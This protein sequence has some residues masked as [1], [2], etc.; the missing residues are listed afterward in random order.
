MGMESVAFRQRRVLFPSVE[1][2]T[3]PAGFYLGGAPEMGMTNSSLRRITTR[4]SQKYHK[5]GMLGRVSSSLFIA[6]IT[7]AFASAASG[8]PLAPRPL[9]PEPLEKYDNPPAPSRMVQFSPGRVSQFGSFTSY[10]VNVDGNGNNIVGDAANEPSICVD[11][12]D[13]NKLAIGWRQFDD[14]SSNFRQAGY[15]YSTNG[16]V[17]WTFP[18]VLQDNIFRS[19]PVLN[20]DATG[21]FY[22]LSLLESFY[23]TLW[24]SLNQ[25]QTW[26]NIAPAT[27]GDKQWFVID[28]TNSPGSGFQ[29]QAWSPDGNNYQGRQFS[30]STNGGFSWMN[31]VDIPHT[32]R[33]GTLDVDSSGILYIGG[34][35][36][37]TGQ[38][39]CVRSSN[40]RNG[41]VTPTFDQSTAVNMGGAVGFSESI[42]PAGL[43]GQINLAVDRS[44]SSTNNNVYML[45]S[46]LTAG[47]SNGSDVMFVRSTNGG[48]AF[49]APIRINDDPVNQGRWHWLGAL[50]IAPNGRID[51]IWL[52]SRNA[53]NNTNSQLFYSYS[54]DGGNSW[55]SNIAISNLFDPFIGY[56]NQDKMGDYITLVSD[57]RGAHVA[58]SATFNNEED[59]YYVRLTIAPDAPVSAAASSISANAFT[60]NWS[61]VT[62]ANSYR[63]DVA[64]DVAFSNFVSGYQDLNVGNVTSFNV[65]GL[66]SGSVYYY[67]V[68]ANNGSG[69]SDNSNV[70]MVITLPAAPTLG[71]ASNVTG[72]S[73]TVNWNSVTGATG[74]QLD[75]S[76]TN[77]FGSYV[78]GYQNRDVGNMNSFNVTG[79][80]PNTIYY[81]R[82]RAYNGSGASTNSGINSVMTGPAAPT[83]SASNVTTSSFTANW[84]SVSGGS[85]YRLDVS[86]SSS[87]SS[88]VS[89]YQNLSVGN[90]TNRNVTGLSAGGT[91]FYRVRASNGTSASDNSNVVSVTLVPAAPVATAATISFKAF[92][93]NWNASTGA[94]GYRLDVATD[95]SFTNYVPGYQ[96]RDVGNMSSFTVKGLNPNSTY[97][98]RVRAYNVNGI[99]GNSNTITVTTASPPNPTPFPS[100]TPKPSVTPGTSATP[101]PGSTPK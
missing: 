29:Y 34:V 83:A 19:D 35:N 52:D 47:A 88:Y 2:N 33:W 4:W 44:G 65:T 91:Y 21:R 46:L 10:Q 97:Y 12:A 84:N 31:P 80:N 78:S 38:I 93:A 85:D 100:A 96:N 50:G 87:F 59:I 82:V 30:R 68:R 5:S 63:L 11:P 51:A 89:G 55:S 36:L 67:R 66:S 94:S 81:Y 14:V 62:G 73:F 98:Y 25:G 32:P 18:G 16:G 45:A 101:R 75:V 17:S 99:T 28:N 27:G 1:Y 42:N 9:P 74:Y 90:V 6:S 39:W 24:Q 61:L 8:Q 86:T 70:I 41:A 58:Y 20:S 37:N 69:V 53:S 56:P 40:A 3:A 48:Q 26:S 76:T 72:N 43:V 23:V 13:P 92:S 49:S 64:T 77:T 15:A 57:N 79:L 54:I 7:F 71:A 95:I 60:A 22:Y